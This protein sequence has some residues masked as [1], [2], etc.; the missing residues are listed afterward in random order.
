MSNYSQYEHYRLVREYNTDAFQNTINNMI[1]DGWI[2]TG[3]IA[4]YNND[5]IQAMWRPP[6][7]EIVKIAMEKMQSQRPIA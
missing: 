6:L 3:G 5:K 4:Y 1:N 7:P 2:P